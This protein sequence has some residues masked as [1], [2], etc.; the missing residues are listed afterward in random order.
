[1][2]SVNSCDC[3]QAIFAFLQVTA[4]NPPTQ[5]QVYVFQRAA[6]VFPRSIDPTY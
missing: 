6:F 1:M 5:S 2:M 4:A 3:Y